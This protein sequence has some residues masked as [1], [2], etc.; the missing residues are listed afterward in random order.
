ML[1]DGV[2]SRY[3]NIGLYMPASI[4]DEKFATD[5]LTIVT[6]IVQNL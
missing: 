3:K 4:R 1:R 5:V 2:Y 6:S